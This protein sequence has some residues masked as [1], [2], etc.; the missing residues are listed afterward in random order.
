M[1]K[2]V[3]FFLSWANWAVGAIGAKFYKSAN[4]PPP[5]PE[6]TSKE[7][8]PVRNETPKTTDEQGL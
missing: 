2:F 1:K 7:S 6:A 5:T 3:Y 4:K 8:T